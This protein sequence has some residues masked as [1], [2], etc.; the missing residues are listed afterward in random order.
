MADGN[1]AIACVELHV[2]AT[3]Q[4]HS[5][6]VA[7]QAPLSNGTESEECVFN[8]TNFQWKSE[9]LEIKCK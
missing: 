8:S 4:F 6:V 9:P 3:K 2:V 1:S 7:V 5:T